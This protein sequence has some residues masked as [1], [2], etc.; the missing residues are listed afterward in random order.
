VPGVPNNPNLLNGI[1]SAEIGAE[2]DPIQLAGN[3]GYI[4]FEAMSSTPSRER[5]L[6]EVRDRVIE[7]WRVDQIA[8]RLREKAKEAVDKLKTASISEVAAE[9]GTKPQFIA[10]LKRERTQG[11]FPSDALEV[12]F[13][14]PKD[15][16][17]LAEG[18]SSQWIVFRV[19][20]VTEPKVDMASDEAK[21]IQA[22]LVNAY[23]EDI[24]A[25]FIARLQTDLGATINEAALAQ[26]IGGTS[27]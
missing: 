5:P 12:V 11:D 27:N 18:S 23:S 9:L 17:G 26:V 25:Q 19:T 6:D 14:T 4:W 15:Q 24:L 10:G 8:T 16:A 13:R 20:G 21:R 2:N 7:R 1:F 3:N 22:T